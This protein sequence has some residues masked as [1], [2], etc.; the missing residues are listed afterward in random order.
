MFQ[1]IPSAEVG[2]R[3][4]GA[5]PQKVAAPLQPPPPLSTPRAALRLLVLH[6]SRGA[7]HSLF[8]QN[9]PR[10]LRNKYPCSDNNDVDFAWFLFQ[11]KVIRLWRLKSESYA[12]CYVNKDQMPEKRYF[13][14]HVD[15]WLLIWAPLLSIFNWVSSDLSWFD[16]EF[17]NAGLIA[18]KTKWQ[19]SEYWLC[20]QVL[21]A[22][23]GKRR[24]RM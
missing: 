16:R 22:V 15:Y 13:P 18:T 1:P 4:P 17:E 23:F 21:P 3:C 2:R 9:P 5:A 20:F 14:N 19:L 10:S 12:S 11:Q 6:W 24:T 7:R 8:N